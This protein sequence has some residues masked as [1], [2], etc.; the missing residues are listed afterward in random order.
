MNRAHQLPKGTP[1]KI[2]SHLDPSNIGKRGVVLFS[3]G[4]PGIVAYH[5]VQLYEEPGRCI[6]NL[7]GHEVE[8][9]QQ[10][11]RVYFINELARDERGNYIP[12]IAVE[13]EVGI[14]HRTD[15]EWGSDLK[16]AQELADEMNEKMGYGKKEAMLIQLGTMRAR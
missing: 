11:R 15:W 2:V 10:P 9:I 8:P 16:L 3:Q 6:P 7:M 4:L 5:D 12:C 1:V 14:Y 13:G